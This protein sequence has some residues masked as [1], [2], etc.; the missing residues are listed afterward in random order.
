MKKSILVYI[1]LLTKAINSQNLK[2]LCLTQNQGGILKLQTKDESLKQAFKSFLL[3]LQIK[4]QSENPDLIILGFQEIIELK[5][6]ALF[7]A[8][9]GSFF[10]LAKSAV[11]IKSEANID[12]TLNNNELKILLKNY[13]GD[14]FVKYTSNISMSTFVLYKKGD[15]TNVKVLK[16]FDYNENGLFVD[17]EFNNGFWGQKGGSVSLIE[18]VSDNSHNFKIV[19]I[20]SHLDS[21]MS[22]KRFEQFGRLLEKV[23]EFLDGNSIKNFT[24]LFSGD[25]NSRLNEEE[26][27]EIE[28]KFT[29][30]GGSLNKV[31]I[32][33]S[34]S[35]TNE[36]FTKNLTEENIIAMEE[37]DI[38]FAPTYKLKLR[39]EDC[40]N[41]ENF[42]NCYKTEKD[43]QKFAYTDRI[44]YFSSGEDNHQKII[45]EIEYNI[46][47]CQMFSDHFTV[48]GIFQIKFQQENQE[49]IEI[50]NFSGE[51]DILDEIKEDDIE[52]KIKNMETMENQITLERLVKFSEFIGNPAEILNTYKGFEPKEIRIALMD[53]YE[54][55]FNTVNYGIRCQDIDESEKSSRWLLKTIKLVA[56]YVEECIRDISADCSDLII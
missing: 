41:E 40:T 7:S 52:T 8:A 44:L 3:Q 47:D 25:M 36:E 33:K 38:N 10:D 15:F 35:K 26:K 27:N 13:F 12:M 1:L 17:K 29:E 20:N 34:L 37:A 18:F 46:I 16:I 24:L 6:G 32:Y 42:V 55:I 45:N 48:F 2:V 22:S 14:F 5:P 11:G 19:H 9:S 56:K 4:V 54:S 28:Q 51:E 30:S 53:V 39:Q 23:K 49:D 50:Q 31:L 43:K 21:N